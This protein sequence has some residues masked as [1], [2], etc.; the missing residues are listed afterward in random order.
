MLI[1]AGR[2]TRLYI[3]ATQV[4]KA[5]TL[6]GMVPK[7]QYD[8]LQQKVKEMEERMEAYGRQIEKFQNLLE[9]LS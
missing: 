4:E 9:G 1:P 8:E 6:V 5:G 2:D 7:A 3:R